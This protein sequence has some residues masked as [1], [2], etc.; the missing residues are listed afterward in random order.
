MR[1]LQY[2]KEFGITVFTSKAIRKACYKSNSKLAW[3]IN[4]IN[5]KILSQKL[6]NIFATTTVDIESC[7][8]F[9][10]INVPEKPIWIMWFQGLSEAPEVVKMCM[11]SIQK[12]SNG[13]K[14]IIVTEQNL[15]DYIKL[16]SY[17]MEKFKKGQITK[18]HLSDIVRLNLL[19]L[20][21]GLWIDATVLVTEKIPEELFNKEFYSINFGKYT[22]DPS[23][24]RW[25]TF[26]MFGEKGKFV[27]F[28]SVECHCKFWKKYNQI[29]D[30]IMFDYIIDYLV[31]FDEEIRNIVLSV[32]MNNRGVFELR[33]IMNSPWNE[34]IEIKDT[35]FH[36]LTWKEQFE[37]EV[38]NKKT[39]YAKLLEIYC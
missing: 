13:H 32:P 22:K 6:E 9:K 24:G 17:V 11:N 38:N 10:N 8:E 18:T 39:V 37:K 1:K 15:S 30:Y 3:K 2:I 16:P 21:G 29:I 31:Q 4:E 23:H 26:L 19:Y 14:V 28:K 20:Y 5:E 34:K 36:K 35:I 27:F 25:T 12:N 7:L 33:K